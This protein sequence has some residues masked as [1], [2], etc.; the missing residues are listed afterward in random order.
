MSKEKDYLKD[1][2]QIRSMM[3]R[4]SRFLSLSGWAGV[5]AG[6]Y[7]L[8]GAYIAHIFFR[9][10]PAEEYT[11][12]GITD[13]IQIISLAAV[14]LF[15]SVGTAIYLS[16]RRS[17]KRAEPFWNG[18]SRRLLINMGMP[19]LAG[20]IFI[21]A[22]IYW[23]QVSLLAPLTMI[24]YGISLFNAGNFTFGEIRFLGMI[25]VSLG[26]LGA[27]F[28][29]WGLLFWALG[30]GIMHIVYGIYIYLKHER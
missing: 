15:L 6:I 29:Q 20:G 4:S 13:L 7:A 5:M 16:Y 11:T 9:F 23:Q 27:F 8:V 19:L 10:N 26:L 22:M 24:F 17:V 28:P 18:T 1:I 3:E 21:L 14:V 12:T 2:A 25:Q 30:F